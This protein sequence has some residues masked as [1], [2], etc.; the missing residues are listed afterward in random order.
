MEGTIGRGFISE[1]EDKLAKWIREI[2][3][4]EGSNAC[5][6]SDAIIRTLMRLLPDE[7]KKLINS[8]IADFELPTNFQFRNGTALLHVACL[9]GMYTLVEQ[10]IQWG[11]DVNLAV[12]DQHAIDY[13][14]EQRNAPLAELLIKHGAQVLTSPPDEQDR[15]TINK[16]FMLINPQARLGGESYENYMKCNL[17]IIQMFLSSEEYLSKRKQPINYANPGNTWQSLMQEQIEAFKQ[18]VE[19]HARRKK[20][21]RNFTKFSEEMSQ[22]YTRC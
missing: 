4:A 2:S 11:A 5:E 1:H 17:R 3:R 21:T 19:K 16:L 20:K 14:L 9:K 10:L 18:N 12:G 7:R 6:L 8:E 15:A 13:A 22:L